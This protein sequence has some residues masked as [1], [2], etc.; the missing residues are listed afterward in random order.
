M[1]HQQTYPTPQLTPGAHSGKA[2]FVRSLSRER[3][4]RQKRRKRVLLAAALSILILLIV[5]LAQSCS[6][7]DGLQGTWDY[8]GNTVYQF[9][10]KGR[11]ALRL[12]LTSY[13]FSYE[14]RGDQLHI[15]FSDEAVHDGS[16]AFTVNGDTL[17]LIGGEDTIGGSYELHRQSE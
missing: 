12:P 14:I 10:G 3:Q 13:D 9:D 2:Y 8:D 11:G 6:G 7:G 15:D 4:Q 16:Y 5:L 17:T 1:N